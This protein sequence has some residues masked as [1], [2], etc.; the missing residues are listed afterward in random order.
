MASF[1]EGIEI[2]AERETSMC[3]E[4]PGTA[5]LGPCAERTV[6][7]RARE[8]HRWPGLAVTDQIIYY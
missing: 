5:A 6:E 1:T 4:A 3:K 7:T 8:D 2:A